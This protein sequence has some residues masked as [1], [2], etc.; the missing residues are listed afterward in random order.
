LPDCYN[1]LVRNAEVIRQWTILREIERAHG[2][3]ATIHELAELTGV[4]TRTIRRDLEALEAAGFP[5]YDDKSHDETIG[6]ISGVWG[7]ITFVLGR[8][9]LPRR[10]NRP[11][12]QAKPGR[13]ETFAN[14][15]L[16]HG[17]TGRCPSRRTLAALP[18]HAHTTHITTEG[19]EAD[20]QWPSAT[21][22]FA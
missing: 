1:R 18:L 4:T 16:S 5:L 3:G 14:R 8:I 6:N 21:Q 2:G 11:S 13:A 19:V 12:R 20:R 9:A 7:D 22:E 17:T 15:L 10:A